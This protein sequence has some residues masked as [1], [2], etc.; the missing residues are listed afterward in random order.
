MSFMKIR[1]NI[2]QFEL[3]LEFVVFMKLCVFYLIK[4][5]NE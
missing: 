4:M 2:C 3:E 1:R 5:Q